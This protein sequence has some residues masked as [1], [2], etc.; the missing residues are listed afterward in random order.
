MPQSLSRGPK[1]SGFDLISSHENLPSKRR[2]NLII[3]SLCGTSGL[4]EPPISSEMNFRHSL[5]L[6]RLLLI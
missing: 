6:A 2:N 1:W 5:P 4:P 3:S